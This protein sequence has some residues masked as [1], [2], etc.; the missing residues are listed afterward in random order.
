MH[1]KTYPLILV[2]VPSSGFPEL[3]PIRILHAL[4]VSPTG[5]IRGCIQK[6]PDWVI[7]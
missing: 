3:F 2:G 6:S 7:T 5:T 4:L 1:F